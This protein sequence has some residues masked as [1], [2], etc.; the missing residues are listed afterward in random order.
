VTRLHITCLGA[1]Q[2][3]LDGKVIAFDTDKARALL[4]YLA[5]ESDRPQRREHLAGLLWSDVPEERALH[6]LR[7]TL[8]A[9]R[10]ALETEPGE[11]AP[12]LW[13]QRDSVQFNPE[14]A[15][16]LDAA[17]FEEK[18]ASA[19]RYYNHT[20]RPGADSR[21]NLRLLQQATGLFRGPFLDQMY[22]SGSPLF[23]EWASLKREAYNQRMIEALSILADVHERR[24]EIVQ[25]RQYANQIVALAPWDETAQAQAMRLWAVEGQWSAAQAQYHHFRRY[26]HDQMGVEPTTDTQE[27]YERIR[28]A[29]AQNIPLA[30]LRPAARHS[31]PLDATPFC[32]RQQELDALVASLSDPHCHLLTIVGPGGVGKTRLALEAARQQVGIFRDGV[33]FVSLAGLSDRDLLPSTLAE[34]LGFAFYGD[35][36]AVDELIRFLEGRQMLWVLDN[37]EQLLPL[38]ADS[39]VP[40]VLLR[41][42][43]VVIL[44][45]SR[46]RLNLQEECLFPLQGLSYPEYVDS[47][48]KL[49][50]LDA[51][52]LFASRA[53][54]VSPYFRL[55]NPSDRQAAAQ[56]CQLLEGLPLGV[57]L[58]A[59]ALWRHTPA[60]VANRLR[61]NLGSLASTA[62]NTNDRH[63]SLW[64]AFEVSW[65]QLTHDE[66]NFLVRLSVFRGGFEGEMAIQLAAPAPEASHPGSPPA[67]LASLLDKSLVRRSSTGR[68]DLHEAIRQFAAERLAADPLLAQDTHRRHAARF[69]SFLAERNPA[70]KGAGQIAALAEI[71]LEWDNIRHAWAW[72]VEERHTAEIAACAEGVFHFC[73][74][75]THYNE[76]MDFFR[77]ANDCLADVPGATAV[78]AQSL[79]FFG[80]LAYRAQEKDRAAEALERSRALFERVD[81]PVGLAFC[82]LFSSALAY[83]RK[84]HPQARDWCEQ[85]LALFQQAGDRWGQSYALYQLGLLE[86]RAGQSAQAQEAL[87][88]SLEAAQ[89]IG[90]QRRQIAPLNVLGDLA[91]QAGNYAAAAPYFEKCLNLSR[92]LGDRYN[93]SVALGNLGTTLHYTGQFERARECYQESLAVAIEIGDL[94]GQSLAISNLGEASLALRQFDEAQASFEQGLALAQRAGDDYAMVIGLINLGDIA[95]R[96][97]RLATAQERLA[98]AMQTASA[99]QEPTLQLRTLL[100]LGQLALCNG[101]V[102]RGLNLLGLV[103]HHPASEDDHRQVARQALAQAGLPAPEAAR[104]TLVE[105][106]SLASK[107]SA[108]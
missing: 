63:R 36:D 44:A 38:Q 32:G 6:N 12:F 64:A 69:S 105:A 18:L 100:H 98:Q 66:Q 35:E 39:L 30:P 81:A 83:R 84:Q 56:I 49:E 80:A 23:D 57:E 37:L 42:P 73:N 17:A 3:F 78:L 15:A 74:I 86:S 108:R 47:D 104:L 54:R 99:M 65:A 5:L 46:Q 70:L 97:G 13:V 52:Q 14:S 43:G 28:K 61:G 94:A 8:S 89:A 62:I 41:S 106:C 34:A 16:W 67:L 24:A 33:F 1:F 26:L 20:P 76:G 107:T 92:T 101:Q 50:D 60:E 87:Q 90:D 4:A 79:A 71:A 40:Q 82:L 48:E 75:R 95:I 27:L 2:A 93:T 91:C 22:L 10:K 77:Q 85:S 11:A 21:L 68:Y 103:I 72:L 29:A 55:E 59:A 45:T 25:A 53:Q 9:L 96:Q 51:I 31:L 7:Q 88:A 58:A 102:A 19:L